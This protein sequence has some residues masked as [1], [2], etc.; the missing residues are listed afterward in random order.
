MIV[1]GSDPAYPS[2]V[3]SVSGVPRYRPY[4]SGSSS[5]CVVDQHRDVVHRLTQLRRHPG[6]RPLD[7]P[8]ELGGGHI[9]GRSPRYGPSTTGENRA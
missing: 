5:S 3:R 7:D 1:S 8:L 6:Q 2:P 4:S 9:S